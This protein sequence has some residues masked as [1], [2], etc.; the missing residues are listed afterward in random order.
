MSVERGINNSETDQS[1]WWVL[2]TSRTEKKNSLKENRIRFIST[3]NGG[4]QAQRNYSISSISRYSFLG[5]VL[6]ERE[7]SF[8]LIAGTSTISADN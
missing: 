4:E 3:A 2:K 7:F 6:D 1:D 8:A 5:I